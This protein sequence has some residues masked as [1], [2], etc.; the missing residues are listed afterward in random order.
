VGVSAKELPSG[1]SVNDIVISNPTGSLVLLLDGEEVL[2]AKQDRVFDGSVLVPAHSEMQVAVCC[3]ERGR[4]DG[5]G[6]RASFEVS[7]QVSSPR[8]RGTMTSVRD[9][10]SERSSQPDVWASVNRSVIDVRATSVTS[11][12]SD[13][14]RS[15]GNRLDAMTRQVPLGAEQ[16]GAI[17]FVGG[18]FAA[19]DWVANTN[20]YRELHARLVRGYAFDAVS[21]ME[22]EGGVSAEVPSR[23][24]V[25]VLVRAIAGTPLEH[26]GPAGAGR[27]VR[28]TCAR[29]GGGEP[30]HVAGL[31]VWGHVAQVSAV[32]G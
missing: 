26:G 31:E 30:I 13:A 17:A 11:A 12:M 1:P 15:V 25:E 2:G 24:D 8:L 16:R 19:L 28:G 10:V 6:R 20:V 14:Y 29:E 4:W 21:A 22:R 23:E 5:R 32:V 9:R 27:R 18:Q 7:P 3:V